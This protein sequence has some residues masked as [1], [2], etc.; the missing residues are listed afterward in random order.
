VTASLA[1][2]VLVACG[3]EPL[4]PPAHPPPA[5]VRRPLGPLAD[6]LPA[7]PKLV[8]VLKPSEIFA[9]E[10]TRQVAE[11]VFDVR[12]RDRFAGRTGIELVEVEEGILAEYEEGT[13]ILARGP[14]PA[15]DVAKASEVR[16]NTVELRVDEDDG[17]RIRRTGWIGTERYDFAALDE[18]VLFV[19]HGTVPEAVEL[20]DRVDRGSWDRR[21]DGAFASAESR[22]LLRENSDA[23]LAIHSPAPLELGP[24]T[25]LGVLLARETAL[26][27][28][29]ERSET[30]S[31]SLHIAAD[32][33]GEFPETAAENF[34]HLVESMSRN[35]LGAV[36]GIGGSIETLRIQVDDDRARISMDVD[37]NALARGLAIV[38]GG[39]LWELVRG[40]PDST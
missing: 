31:D 14:W 37:A 19:A 16:M 10:I 34:R 3:A 40:A 27:I 9:D 2:L 28:R 35:G 11:S 4:P 32:I 30:L 17:P 8:I 13:I 1:L 23:P 38:V 5:P 15:S 21:E 39:D 29:I 26:A 36:L 6:L 24:D 12:A 18:H 7:G 20:L 25:G 33:R 22:E